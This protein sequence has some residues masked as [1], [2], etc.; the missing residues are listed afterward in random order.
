MTV[1]GI[2]E[3]NFFGQKTTDDKIVK[4]TLDNINSLLASE[5]LTKE[6]AEK[7]K[8]M[9]LDGEVN[10]GSDGLTVEEAANFDADDYNNVIQEYNQLQSQLNSQKGKSNEAKTTSYVVQAGDT[11][12]VIAKK[13]GLEG[14]EAKKFASELKES[15][16]KAGKYYRFGFKAGDVIELP[17]DYSAK[18]NQMKQDGEYY[19]DMQKINEDYIEKTKARET[20]RNGETPEVKKEDSAAVAENEEAA[21]VENSKPVHKVP[22]PNTKEY[23]EP[24]NPKKISLKDLKQDAQGRYIIPE[25]NWAIDSSE[26]PADD[27]NFVLESEKSTLVFDG[28]VKSETDSNYT[29][30]VTADIIVRNSDP[31]NKNYKSGD[32]EFKNGQYYYKGEVIDPSEWDIDVNDVKNAQTGKVIGFS[33]HAVKRDTVMSAN[34]I[35]RTER[36]IN[37]EGKGKFYAKEIDCPIDANVGYFEVDTLAQNARG[38]ISGDGNIQNINTGDASITLGGYNNKVNVRKFTSGL[39]MGNNVNVDYMQGG[40]YTASGTINELKN[41]T[42]SNE[43]A[44]IVIMNGGHVLD[45][46]YIKVMQNG[47]LDLYKVAYS[48]PRKTVVEYYVGGQIDSC[49]KSLVVIKNGFNRG[50]LADANSE[51][52]E[53]RGGQIVD[54]EPSKQTPVVEQPQENLAGF[55]TT[56]W[57]WLKGIF[58]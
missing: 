21:V 25:G 7:L 49:D 10:F 23:S 18:I 12:A 57:N 53:K 4:M 42:V 1:N 55:G 30:P 44:N 11:P 38:V 6:M 54:K 51:L 48:N 20:K 28:P 3:V 14:D 37:I 41:G 17:G 39:V 43:E 52:K 27:I 19:T 40:E 32:F 34:E 33:I 35:Q 24:A 47:F 22:N 13:L 2:G 46:K 36:K 45:A 8:E 9:F 16:Q 56:V 29:P 26:L 58:S 15:A 5:V 50:M 31:Q